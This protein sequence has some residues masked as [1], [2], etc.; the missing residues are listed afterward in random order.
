MSLPSARRRANAR[1]NARLFVMTEPLEARRMLAVNVGINFQPPNRPV[2]AGY[3]PD[4]GRTY[5][6]YGDGFTYGW[7]VA[8]TAYRDRNNSLSPDQRYDT[9]THT[10]LYGN[11]T[12][13]L[14]VPNGTYSV[15][16]AAGDPVTINA[17]YGIMVEGKRAV[18]GA[19][20]QDMPWV[21][22]TVTV[23]VT[24]GTLTLRRAVGSKN[25]KLNFI[26]IVQQS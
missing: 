24:D 16:V 21:G 14:K 15:Y 19:P 4:V 17:F 3:L 26:Q 5:S 23:E 11:R 6:D 10:Q 12:W 25:N 18:W 2:P 8:N 20:T 7:D 22:G 9:L 13:A 1:S